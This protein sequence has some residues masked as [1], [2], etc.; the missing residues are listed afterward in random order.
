MSFLSMEKRLLQEFKI[1]D[2][3]WI[4]YI[5]NEKKHGHSKT[6][7][8]DNTKNLSITYPGYKTS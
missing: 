1:N 5:K 7:I 2:D 6:F 8:I 4:D 3:I